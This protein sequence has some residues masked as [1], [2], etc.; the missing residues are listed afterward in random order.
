MASLEKQREQ[1]MATLVEQSH[2]KQSFMDAKK[3]EMEAKQKHTDDLVQRYQ[4]A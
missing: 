3:E 2:L 4:Y 1:L